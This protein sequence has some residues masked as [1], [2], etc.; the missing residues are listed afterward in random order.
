M[1]VIHRLEKR[2]REQFPNFR[3]LITP[4]ANDGGVYWLDLTKGRR[5]IVIEVHASGQIGVSDVSDSKEQHYGI[6]ADA[7][8]S[9]EDAAFAAAVELMNKPNES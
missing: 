4:P 3:A 9:S 6:G 7:A 8:Y 5:H 2:L 1:H